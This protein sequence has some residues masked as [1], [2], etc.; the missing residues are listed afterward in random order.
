MALRSLYTVTIH[1]NFT[2]C[3]ILWRHSVEAQLYSL[4][5]WRLDV[6]GLSVSRFG[7]FTPGHERLHIL[8]R[9]LIG[10]QDLSE[11]RGQEKIFAPTWLRNPNRPTCKKSFSLYIYIYIYTGCPRWNVPDFGRVF[12]MLKY[13]YITQNTYIQIWTVTEI[14]TR[15]VW[16][17]D[18]CYTLIDYQI[19]IE[20][21]RNMWFL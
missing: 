15:E 18:S 10:W 2:P 7:C 4:L 14:M 5:N 16:N 9:R 20:T 8:H 11:T 1:H 6:G 21:G 17:F 19:H 3:S 12:L 13:T